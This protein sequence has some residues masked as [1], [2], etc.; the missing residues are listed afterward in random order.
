MA[1]DNKG[2]FSNI[3]TFFRRAT[4]ALDGT[5]GRLEAPVQKEFITAASQE[6]AQKKAVE[7]GAIKFYRGQSTKID[8]GNDQRKLMYESS[9]MMLYYD[10]LSMDGYPILG[11]ALDLLAE[12]ATTTKSDTGQI[13]NVY[14]SSDKVKKELERFFYKVMDANTNLFYWCRNMCQYGDNFI[15]LELSKENGIVDFR[16]LAS[17][18]VERNEKYDTKQRF[19][20]FFKYKDPNSG[21]EEEYMDYQVAHF[22]LLGTGDRL[23]Y[24]CSVYEKVRRTYKQLF[25]MEDAMMVYRI[26]RA[27]ERRIYKV[28]V[29]NVPPEDVPQI[30]EAFANNVKKKKLVDPKTGDINFKYNIASMDEDIFIA[31]RGNTSGQF[32]D[33]LPGACL[34]LDT[35][36]K[37]LDGRS[38]ELNNIIE[39]HN[40]GNELWTYSINPNTGEIVPGKI[41]WAGITRK[42]TDVIKLTLDNGQSLIVTPDHKIPTRLNGVKEAKDIILGESLWSFN[43]KHNK[44]S[45]GRSDYEMYF[46]H[47]KN[48]WI[49]THR[50]V[51]NFFKNISEH[52]EFL[53]DSN[54]TDSKKQTIHHKDFNSKNNNPNNLVFMNNEDHRFYHAKMIS[55][56]SKMGVEA[57]L[58]KFNND[59]EFR[60]KLLENLKNER[61]NY[62][63]NRDENQI[64]EHNQNI[65]KGIKNYF[66]NIDDETKSKKA[67]ISRNNLKKVKE[68]NKVHNRIKNDLIFKKNLYDKVSKTAKIRK[69]TKEYKEKASINGKKIWENKNEMLKKVFTKEQKITFTDELINIFVKTLKESNNRFDI[70]INKLNKNENFIK[71]FSES[72]KEIRS[73][74]FSP[75]FK[76]QHIRKIANLLGLKNNK[77]LLNYVDLY[78]HTVINIEY[79]SEKIDTGTITVDGKEIYHNYHNFALDCG[80]FVNNSNLEA[81]S[82]I[83]YLRDN[84]FTGLG[85]HKTLLGFSSDQASGDGKNLSMLDIRFARKVNRIQQALLGELNKIAIIHLGLLGGDYESYIDDF[86]LSL[87]NPSTASD[88]LQLEIWK[89]KLEVYQASTTPNQ[90]TGIKPMSE[91]MAKKRFFHMSEEDIINDLQEQMLE[92]KVG[93]EIKGAGMLLKSSGLMDKMIKYKNAGFKMEGQ[94]QGEQQQI[95]NS[96]GGGL[97]GPEMGGAPPLGGG[98]E[99]GGAEGSLPPPEGGGGAS[100]GAGFLSEEIFKKTDELTRLIKE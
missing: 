85:I 92:S 27:A 32:V 65:S 53:F 20:A 23:P 36:I 78:N 52:N 54:Y 49:Y 30:L 60:E 87:N 61:I 50:M 69:N 24:G 45:D 14:C 48:K 47:N 94:P 1:E 58:D 7:D 31:D 35:K 80:I 33:T 26:T 72:N 39:E 68:E 66:K 98:P 13:L 96:L 44:F 67:D 99:A 59:L 57:W 22:R 76:K 86:K 40:N 25:M 19:R 90:N 55:D 100:G 70:T 2:L 74:I 82:D 56:F 81:I 28:P 88:L 16:Q 11:A 41:T 64:K 18:F 83:N 10:Y 21:G 43:T 17:Q 9:R 37:L 73:S 97:G 5:Q 62:Y 91:M 38:L 89:S 93:E 51:A 77:E 75:V 46:D 4:D 29:G 12:E 34:S 8:R 3:N 95:D 6:E 63:K 71:I 79:L 42:N 15:Y 84:L